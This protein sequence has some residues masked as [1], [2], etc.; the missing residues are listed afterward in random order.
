MLLTVTVSILWY[1]RDLAGSIQASF[2]EAPE[3]SRHYLTYFSFFPHVSSFICLFPYAPLSLFPVIYGMPVAPIGPEAPK[4]PKTIPLGIFEKITFQ[5]AVDT[6]ADIA[7]EHRAWKGRLEFMTTLWQPT[8]AAA[9]ERLVAL[10]MG[11]DANRVRVSHVTKW[12]QGAFNN[13]MPV[14]IYDQATDAL[15]HRIGRQAPEDVIGVGVR[16]VVLRCP[17]AANCATSADNMGPILEK[18]RVEVAMYVWMQRHCPEIRIPAL[19]A[20]GLPNGLH[21]CVLSR[22][23]HESF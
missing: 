23:F 22:P 7:A 9:L 5:D 10:H 17:I 1:S 6:Q 3:C 2:Q 21:V 19:Y 8:R 12:R 11:V 16:R 15:D 13:S 18:M 20:F 4:V 14:L